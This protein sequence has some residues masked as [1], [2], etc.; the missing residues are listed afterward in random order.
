MESLNSNSKER[1]MQ[2]TQRLV[3]QR[4]S[5]CMAWF[6]Q[7][8]T[9]LR[10]LYLNSSPHAVDAFK[11]AFHSFFGEEHQTFRLKMF[12]NL[13]QLRLQLEKEN[14]LEVNPRRLVLKHSEHNSRNFF[15]PKVLRFVY[16]VLPNLKTNTAFCLG[17]T[18]PNSF[19]DC[20]LSQDLTAFYPRLFIAFCLQ[21]N[22]VL[23]KD[24]H[25]DLLPA[26][27]LLLKTFIAFC[28]SDDIQAAGSDTRPPMLDR[29]DYES[30]SQR[31]RLYYRGKENG[32]YI[33]QSINQ[34]PFKLGTTRDTLV[35]TPEGGVLLGPERPRTYDD[36]NDNDKK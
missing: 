18:L 27:C 21:Q 8:E 2:L 11:P 22:Y 17:E 19:L 26:F 32:I 34:G 29:T 15:P 1:E 13:D 30:W 3:K 5:H 35:T 33:L 16:C 9:H 20:V 23:S 24:L 4:H 7:L 36:L 28:N 6:E 14:L 31:I 10:D 25:R 12:R